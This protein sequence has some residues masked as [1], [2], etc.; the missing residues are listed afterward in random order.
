M[1]VQARSAEVEVAVVAVDPG[2]CL[3]WPAMGDLEIAIDEVKQLG[4]RLKDLADDLK[5]GDGK[6]SYDVDELGHHK[7]IDAME[8]FHGNWNDNRDHLADKL[9]TLGDLAV[10]TADTFTEADEDLARE[11]NKVMEE[12]GR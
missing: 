6:K 4:T 8:E 2:S 11:I 1:R 9:S 7:V 5:S 12:S 3:D 10:E